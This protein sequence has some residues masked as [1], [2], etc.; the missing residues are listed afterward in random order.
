[1][2]SG[3]AG[4]TGVTDCP[5]PLTGPPTSR[6]RFVRA[7]APGP[8]F[9]AVALADG[10]LPGLLDFD[11]DRAK[12]RALSGM[13]PVTVRQFRTQAALAVGPLAWR[14]F[15]HDR[16]GTVF[17]LHGFRVSVLASPP[18]PTLPRLHRP[19]PSA[20]MF[21]KVGTCAA[22]GMVVSPPPRG[23]G[24]VGHGRLAE[25]VKARGRFGSRGAESAALFQEERGTGRS[26]RAAFLISHR[27]GQRCCNAERVTASWGAEEQAPAERAPAA[28][29]P[30]PAALS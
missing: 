30:G 28:H 5:S 8:V 18:S 12:P 16:G 23:S 27:A 3:R 1:M 4:F 11:D 22:S 25:H 2:T 14:L 9:A 6:W 19:R 15:D 17:R 7:V 24:S 26:A 21:T 20:E 13:R 29:A 10:P